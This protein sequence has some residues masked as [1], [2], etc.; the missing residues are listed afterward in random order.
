MEATMGRVTTKKN[1]RYVC[2]E[3]TADEPQVKDLEWGSELIVATAYHY[4]Q[5][6]AGEDAKGEVEILDD[7]DFHEVIVGVFTSPR[8]A[9]IGAETYC[10]DH[11]LVEGG[12]GPVNC[13]NIVQANLNQQGIGVHL[14]SYDP[15]KQE[16]S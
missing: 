8:L 7:S 6:D 11:V 15:S 9:K 16:W 2:P 10:D 3:R 4:A 14:N 12:N 1:G 5:W 13:V